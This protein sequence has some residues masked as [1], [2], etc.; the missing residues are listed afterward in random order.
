M[1]SHMIF[2]CFPLCSGRVPQAFSPQIP[3]FIFYVISSAHWLHIYFKVLLSQ[4]SVLFC[5]EHIFFYPAEDT[6]ELP[7]IFF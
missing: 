5:K 1:F 2:L 7:E 4:V 6:K 3:A